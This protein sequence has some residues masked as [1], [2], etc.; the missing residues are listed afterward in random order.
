[1]LTFQE[2]VQ[3]F[4]DI[5][6]VCL[7]AYYCNKTINK[8]CNHSDETVIKMIKRLPIKKKI[9]INFT[10]EDGIQGQRTYYPNG[11]LAEE[12]YYYDD[13]H[14]LYKEY[15]YRTSCLIIEYNYSEGLL[16]GLYKSYYKDGTLK[17]E[18]FYI[19]DLMEGPYKSYHKNGTLKEERFYVKD[20]MD[21][22]YK[23]YDPSGTIIDEGHYVKVKKIIE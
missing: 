11:L 20:L 21:G 15:H 12:I 6:I 3:K 23:K 19:K 9:W 18:G 1:M 2:S 14:E 8:Y 10:N 4:P 5:C 22:P 17:E 7:E 13:E 16:D